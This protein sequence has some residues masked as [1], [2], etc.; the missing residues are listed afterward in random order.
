VR[1]SDLSPR[2]NLAGAVGILLLVAS[3]LSYPHYVGTACFVFPG[4]LLLVMVVL[5]PVGIRRF[6]HV[7]LT[8]ALAAQFSPRLVWR[9]HLRL[10]RHRHGFGSRFEALYAQ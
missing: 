4:T 5:A 6:H 1:L 2:S 9:C 8:G 10:R 7:Y 3:I